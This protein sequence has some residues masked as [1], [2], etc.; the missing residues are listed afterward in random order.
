M[1]ENSVNWDNAK[2]ESVI[3]GGEE[4]EI[5]RLLKAPLSEVKFS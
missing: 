3:G 5:S 2:G 1:D 4:S